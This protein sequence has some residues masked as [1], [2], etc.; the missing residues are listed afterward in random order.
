MCDTNILVRAIISPYGSAAELVRIVVTNHSL[1]TSAYILSELYNVLRRPRIRKLHKLS[2]AKIRRLV[3][4]FHQIS[5]V[6]SLPEPLPAVVLL[7]PKD[8]PIVMTAVAGRAEVLCTLDRHLREPQVVGLCAR[9]G[10]RVLGDA[11]LLAKL[12]SGE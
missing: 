10:V 1:V 3:S 7:D 11:E 5:R 8:N 4:R 2:D 12:G 9:Q 6:V